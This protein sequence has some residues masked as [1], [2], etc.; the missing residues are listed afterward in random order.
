MFKGKIHVADD[1]DS[2]LDDLKDD[3]ATPLGKL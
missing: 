2:P 1:F 3:R